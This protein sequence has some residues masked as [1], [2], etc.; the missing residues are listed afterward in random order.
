MQLRKPTV[1]DLGL[2]FG[3][4]NDPLTIRHSRGGK[5]VAWETHSRWL[6][7]KL[8]DQNYR[9]FVGLADD[10]SPCGLVWFYK[11]ADG[12]FETSLNLASDW[13][14]KHVSEPLLRSAILGNDPDSV[15]SAEIHNSNVVAIRVFRKCGFRLAYTQPD[16][17]TYVRIKEAAAS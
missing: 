11:N 14:G 5:P 6:P 4:I 3:W 15:Y 16:I 12:I 9:F 17:S 2:L 10:E 13:R 8:L 7:E 1:D